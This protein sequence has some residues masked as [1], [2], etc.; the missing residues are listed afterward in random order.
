MITRLTAAMN[1]IPLDS[2]DERIRL[3]D[4]IEETPDEKLMTSAAA[5]SIGLRVTGRQRRCLKVKL[6]F[7]IREKDAARR[8]MLLDRVR[9]WAGDGIL[10]IGTRPDQ[11]L[12]VHAEAL[13]GAVS[14]LNWTQTISMTLSAYA[15]PFWEDALPVRADI[16]A[17][18]PVTLRPGGTEQTP[19]L[20]SL[21]NT[22]E[23]TL[24]TVTIRLRGEALRLT[25]LG[26]HSG[27]TI[28]MDDESGWPELYRE[29]D[30]VRIIAQDCRTPD[31][32]D[33]LMLRPGERNEVEVEAEG[34]V[35]G[36]VWGRG[37]CR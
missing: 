16:G 3:T 37:R 35:S 7:V 9:R 1:G 5:S 34:K 28:V 29:K 2:L 19:L 21:R 12:R 22:G 23:E 14:A 13:P 4:I 6:R 18:T 17:G 27:E 36:K 31:S 30:G 15:V 25:G 33:A 32:P 8:A 26:L 11:R 10:T 20:F 24:D